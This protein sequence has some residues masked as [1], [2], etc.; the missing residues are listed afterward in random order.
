MFSFF[1]LTVFQVLAIVSYKYGT[2][3]LAF[4]SAIV[5]SKSGRGG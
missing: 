1:F 5:G 3:E 2:A 4:L